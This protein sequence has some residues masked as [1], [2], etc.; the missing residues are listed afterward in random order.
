MIHRRNLSVAV[1]FMLSFTSLVAQP[2][3]DQSRIARV[4]N[5]LVTPVLV[6]GGKTWNILE[7]MKFYNVPGVSVAVFSDNRI[8]WAKGYGVMD[9]DTGLPVTEKTLFVAGSVSKPVA[10]MGALRLVEEKKLSLDRNINEFLTSWK[11]PEND[12]TKKTPVTLRLIVSHNAG[13]T[14]HGFPGYVQGEKVPTVVQILD[15]AAPANT[16]PIRVDTE[17]GTV[18][19][20]SGGGITIMQLAMADVSGKPFTEI[21]QEKVLD[22]IGMT[23]SSYEQSL[24]PE[25]LALAA[26]GHDRSGHVIPGK[27]NIY[28]EMAAAGLWTT[29]TDLARFAIEAGLSARGASNKVLST[30]M[31]KLMVTPRMVTT[32]G[33][34]MALGFFVETHGKSAYYGHGGADAGF[35]C[36]LI[37]QREGGYGAAIMTN[38]DGRPIPLIRE[39]QRSI[40][41]E[42]GWDGYLP[43]PVE[44]IT[45]GPG[46]LDKSTG[47]YRL[48]SD[49]VLN[50]RRDGDHL[51][52][53]ESVDEDFQLLPVSPSEFIR[54][55]RDTRYSFPVVGDRADSAVVRT[56]DRTAS[57]PRMHNILFAPIELLRLG[58]MDDAV[59]GYRAIRKGNPQDDA[60]NENRLNNL[61]YRFLG[62][63]LYE[64][65]IALFALNVEFYPASW[66]VYDSLGEGYMNRGDRQLAIE[67]YERSL[68]LNPK[69]TNGEKIL[70]KLKGTK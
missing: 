20:Y 69:N 42:Y 28:P 8:Q 25:R 33:D 58:Q 3:A 53:R 19:R 13:M 36:M 37:A 5:G 22:P 12:L 14:I 17:P 45:L 48:G 63:K 34:S 2:G 9:V 44:V 66:N 46:V 16:E 57:A 49:N 65:A 62:E 6:K 24:S 15:G 52:A 31:A 43:A 38:S 23:S 51:I 54:T 1:L 55:D 70:E 67:N 68:K 50:V 7:R 40:A 56:P 11:L 27:R 10:V 39:I 32:E 21:M 35:I 41:G 4:E 18:W 64:A 26:S 60:V 30:A 47:R 61:G 29:P 59:E